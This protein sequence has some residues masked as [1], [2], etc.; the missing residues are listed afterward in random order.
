MINKQVNM[1]FLLTYV[2]EYLL[3]YPCDIKHWHNIE[4][5]IE[6]TWETT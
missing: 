4:A 2:D 5:I 6:Y 1:N 3:K